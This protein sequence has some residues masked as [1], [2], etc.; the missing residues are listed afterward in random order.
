MK[1][2]A[3]FVLKRQLSSAAQDP[4]CGTTLSRDSDQCMCALAA[5]SMD[6]LRQNLSRRRHIFPVPTDNLAQQ[7]TEVKRGPVGAK[8]IRTPL[9]PASQIRHNVF[10]GE[11]SGSEFTFDRTH[12]RS[13]HYERVFLDVN[14]GPYQGKKNTS[15]DNETTFGATHPRGPS[16]V[17]PLRACIR[18]GV[19]VQPVPS[20]SHP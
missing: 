16:N 14:T 6:K 20:C 5:S 19:H 9:R 11:F 3:G 17:G 18:L 13:G 1:A 7:L 2:D 10:L 8:P 15:L 4:L 12:T